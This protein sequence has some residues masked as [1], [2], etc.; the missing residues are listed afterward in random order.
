MMCCHMTLLLF[1]AVTSFPWI[2]HVHRVNFVLVSGTVS[3]GKTRVRVIVF[4]FDADCIDSAVL[5]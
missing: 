1:S 5:R 2:D 3:L 4:Y